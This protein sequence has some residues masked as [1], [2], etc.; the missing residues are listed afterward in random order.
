MLLDGFLR[1]GLL[2]HRRRRS[3][4]Q[5]TTDEEAQN[6]QDG[7][8]N[9]RQAR[10]NGE[11]CEHAREDEEDAVVAEKLRYHIRAEVSLRARARDDEACRRRDEQRRNLRDESLADG[12]QRV[13][14]ERLQRAE[15]PLQHTDDEAA[16][17]ID[18]HD[19]DGRDRIAF[20]ELRGA[21][22][23]AEEVRL[24]LDLLAPYLRLRVRDGPLIEVG[25]DGHL[26]AG[27]RV[28]REAR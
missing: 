26:L 1:L 19:D 25:V 22:H 23:R 2:R 3:L 4:L 10:H 28:E 18:E 11:K 9:P 5:R 12:E 8:R 20:D 14:L 21:V 24:V 27:H 7:K 17:D 6:G 16:R 13:L 15:V